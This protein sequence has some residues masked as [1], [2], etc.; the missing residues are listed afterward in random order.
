MKQKIHIFGASGSGT[1]SIAQAVAEKLG[2]K[3]FDS[4]NYL[5]LPTAE[6][7][8][9]LRPEEERIAMLEKD[10]ASCNQWVE[11]GSLCGWGD[12][13]IPLFDLVVFVYVPPDIR[14]ERLKKR[15][16]QR[17]GDATLPGGSRYES[18]I[19]FIEWAAGY[20]SGL[21][22]GR[23]L[24]KH[25]SWLSGITCDVLRIVNLDFDESVNAVVNFIVEGRTP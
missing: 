21:L 17:Y 7:F 1:S 14:V 24:P 23:S 16:Y 2:Y 10:L 13:F 15:E 6:P 19:E 20:D 4:D 12:I 22:T 5:W 8:T 9:E 3:H 18:T 11:S 25:E